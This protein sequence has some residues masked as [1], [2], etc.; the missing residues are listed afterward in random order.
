M[1]EPLIRFKGK[2][3]KLFGY[4]IIDFPQE[5]EDY[6]EIAKQLIMYAVF[7]SSTY[8]VT[9][10]DLYEEVKPVIEKYGSTFASYNSKYVFESGLFIKGTFIYKLDESASN[11]GD[12]IKGSYDNRLK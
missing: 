4:S 2:V 7:Y 5:L 12:E 11:I 1:K 8:G 10:L 6:K 3:Y 9:Y